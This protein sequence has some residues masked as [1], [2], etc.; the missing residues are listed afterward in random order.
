MHRK[1]QRVCI[2]FYVK[3]RNL[4]LKIRE[5]LQK[6]LWG[7][8]KIKRKQLQHFQNEAWVLYHDN[9]PTDTAREFLLQKFLC[10][11]HQPNLRNLVL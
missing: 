2:K 8:E 9:A 7:R 5:M 6:R 10:C 4:G 3:I 1:E 11:T